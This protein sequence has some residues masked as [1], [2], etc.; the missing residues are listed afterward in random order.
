MTIRVGSLGEKEVLIG[1][2]V[3]IEVP[4]NFV[5]SNK[6]AVYL[7][8]PDANEA[9]PLYTEKGLAITVDG[10]DIDDGAQVR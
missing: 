5:K 8:S 4:P 9:L 6:I 7:P 2:P 10:G 3:K 1:R